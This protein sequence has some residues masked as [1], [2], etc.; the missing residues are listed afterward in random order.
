MIQVITIAREYGSGGAELGRL[1][2]RK[3]GWEL[4]DRQ[5]ADRVARIAGLDP[6]LAGSL[7]EQAHRWW[8]WIFTG[9]SYGAFYKYSAPGCPDVVDENFVHGITMRLIQRAA[10]SGK[11]VIVGRGAQVFLHGRT[12]VFNVL[13]Y[14]PLE[15]RIRRLRARHADCADVQALI[16]QMDGQRAK[17]VREYYRRDWLDRTL[18]DLCIN[19][20]LGLEA[21]AE[22]VTAAISLVKKEQTP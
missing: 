6:K 21:A 17:Y 10:D 14:A 7:D 16:R 15:Q 2:A 22:L 11:C 8:Q 3:L 9:M 20:A 4:L 1:V 13:A 5:L 12:D 19:T 18:Y